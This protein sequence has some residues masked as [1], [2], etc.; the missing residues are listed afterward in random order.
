V[1]VTSMLRDIGRGCR[2]GICLLAAAAQ[3]AV[4][5]LTPVVNQIYD[6]WPR[7]WLVLSVAILAALFRG[8]APGLTALAVGVA[9]I[10]WRGTHF[11]PLHP[12][13][14]V[15]AAIGITQ[16][17]IIH[18]LQVTQRELRERQ[19]AL[20]SERN[21]ANYLHEVAHR[22]N[23]AKDDFLA[24]LSHELRTP[25]NVILGYSRMLRSGTP[26]PDVIRRASQILETNAV[27]QMRIVEDLL[28]VQRIRG[29][30]KVE[31]APFQ[32]RTL[33]ESVLDSLRPLAEAKNQHCVGHFEDV[34][35]EADAARLQQALWN[36]FSNAIKFTPEGG[37]IRLYGARI[38]T[39]LIITVE[40]SGQGIPADFLPHVFEPFRQLDMTSTRRHGGLG[41]GLAIVKSIV[42]A[43]GGTI[44][45][46]SDGSGARFTMRVPAVA[47]GSRVNQT[48]DVA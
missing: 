37:C 38:A 3:V 21:R 33:G 15:F 14:E 12:G 19:V 45:A 13:L 9:L 22:A 7:G 46:E 17:L 31:A 30:M 39:D 1:T 35:V 28:D 47:A 48:Q 43:H 41:L 36:L 44:V 25:L 2:P 10:G 42:E 29:G 40:D 34:V 32:L 24:V 4:F 6:G 27:A 5:H 18:R 16:I 8:A 11:V 20:E 23:R 26:G